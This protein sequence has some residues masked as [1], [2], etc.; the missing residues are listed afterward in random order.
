MKDILVIITTF[1]TIALMTVLLVI[2]LFFTMTYI[3]QNFHLIDQAYRALH[4]VLAWSAVP[5]ATFTL[6]RFLD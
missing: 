2:C 4:M 1:F 6:S 3:D 5:I